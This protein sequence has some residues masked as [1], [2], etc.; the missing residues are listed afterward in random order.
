[1][2]YTVPVDFIILERDLSFKTEGSTFIG[3]L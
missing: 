3:T 1:V 2:Q